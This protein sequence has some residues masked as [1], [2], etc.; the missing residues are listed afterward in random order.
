MVLVWVCFH[1]W[2]PIRL[3]GPASL[4]FELQRLHQQVSPVVTQEGVG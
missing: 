4:L 1:P 3:E 2:S